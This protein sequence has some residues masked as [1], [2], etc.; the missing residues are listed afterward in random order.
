M[1]VPARATAPAAV[2]LL[3]LAAVAGLAAAGPVAPAAPLATADHPVISQF[4]V[5]TR[6]PYVTFGSPFIAITNPTGSDLDLS[7]VYLTDATLMPATIYSN[8]TLNDPVTANPGGGVGGDFHARFPEGYVLPAGATLSVALSGSAQYL[9]AYGRQPDFELY[10]DENYV[11]DTVPELVAAF[12]GSIGAG[13]GGGGTNVP[14]LSDV[15]ES[16]VLYS[17]DG[18]SDLVQDLDY[19]VWGTSTT[20]RVNK[21]GLTVGA[22]SYLN[23]TPVA[24]QIPVAIAGPTFGHAF[25]RVSADEGAE[26]L[27]GG[28]GLGGHNETSENLS[29]TWSDVVGSTPPPAPAAP[30]PSAPIFT[31]ASFA[32]SVPWAGLAVPLS[33]TVKSNSPLTEVTFHYNVDGG[34]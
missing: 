28:N 5:K 33:V 29:T 27:T 18:L 12:P 14:A 15:T 30:F 17:W 6:L 32:P 9:A 3:A 2:L 1:A 21:T 22:S 24:A 7:N 10:E 26:T 8:L 31:A 25:R 23:D 20:I 16:I 11:P 13:M 34:A 19:V 4:V